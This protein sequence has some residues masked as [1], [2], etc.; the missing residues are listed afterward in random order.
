VLRDLAAFTNHFRTKP[1][2]IV[3]RAC[4]CGVNRSP[5]VFLR[6]RRVVCGASFYCSPEP[7]VWGQ[8]P[9][10]LSP[11]AFGALLKFFSLA[12]DH[13]QIEFLSSGPAGLQSPQISKLNSHVPKTFDF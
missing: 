7:G 1:S 13:D 9:P 2:D 10:I 11:K 4:C 3:P 5:G 8:R 6:R 12:S